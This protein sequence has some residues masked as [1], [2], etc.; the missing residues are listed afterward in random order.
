MLSQHRRAF[1]NTVLALDLLVVG[2]A[3]TCA[4][5][6]SLNRPL[7]LALELAAAATVW[8]ALSTRVG[9]YVSRRTSSLLAEIWLLAQV[10]L[11]VAGV[12]LVVHTA[13][14]QPTPL[15]LGWLFGVG[16]GGTAGLRLFV[17]PLLRALRRRGLNTRNYLFI[18]RGESAHRMTESILRRRDYGI[19]I[20]GELA[21]SGEET[22]PPIAGV[23]H[24]GT[25][26]ELQDV[27][28]KHAVDEIVVCPTDGVWAT[29]V[30]SL[31]RFCQTTGLSWRLAPDC[32]GI[33][34]DRSA[35]D[36]VGEVAT[37]AMAGGFGHRRW[38]WVK[39]GI[40]IVGASIGLLLLAPL[41]L[42]IGIAILV[43][44]GRPIFFRQTRVG[45]NGRLF[46][47]HKFRSMVK[48]AEAMRSQLAAKNEQSGPVFKMKDDPRITAVGRFIRR[49]S[50]DELP[51][52]F[53]V[54]RGD[55][56]LV[57]P[58]PPIPSE[59]MQ[60][61]WWQRRR[62][63]VRPGLTCTWQV[64]GRNAITFEKWMEMD[65]AYIDG[66]NLALDMKI[67]AKTVKEVMRGGGA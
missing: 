22:R 60:Y 27:L 37:Y 14:Q 23:E 50:L 28:K 5:M 57:G 31:L 2:T 18:G 40:D 48:N 46:H 24:L 42:G 15:Y 1:A 59:V 45:V 25:T 32:F 63:S 67:M 53:N 52:L 41:M 16:I 66:W 51:Q 4:S 3:I 12:A 58:R 47:M 62:L 17:R 65:L 56:S 10:V 33:P 9:L 21:F 64:S 11:L 34:A 26:A 29:E 30:K 43:T 8:V 20:V 44:G 39:R 36:Y 61:D 19:H 35:V 55:M 54:L 6:A 38:L 49:Y 7:V 13:A